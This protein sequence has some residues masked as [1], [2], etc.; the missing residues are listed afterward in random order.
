MSVDLRTRADSEQ[1]PVQAGVFFRETLPPLL[2]ARQAEIAPGARELPLPDFCIETDG[3]PW[4]LAWQ[5]DRAAV[6]PG[7]ESRARVRLSSQQLSDLVN[8]QSTPIALMSNQL[9]DMPEGGLPDFL[10]WWLVLRAAVDGLRERLGGA[11]PDWLV[12]FASPVHAPRAAEISE[13]LR[14]AF[15]SAAL[16]GCT[17]RSVIG[18]GRELDGGPGLALFA[19]DESDRIVQVARIDAFVGRRFHDDRM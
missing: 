17:A 16:L 2:D 18:G 12:S 11:P 15:P 5:E 1:T 7:R 14:A 4:T 8:D 6:K 13:R 3:E 19:V 10:N 9:L